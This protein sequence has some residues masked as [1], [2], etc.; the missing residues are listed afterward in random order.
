MPLDTTQAPPPSAPILI[1][2]MCH[3][4]HIAPA[5]SIYLLRQGPLVIFFQKRKFDNR[6]L[7]I[8]F[9]D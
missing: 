9:E 8:T 1:T 2:G 3:L 6:R 7:L 5:V 4:A